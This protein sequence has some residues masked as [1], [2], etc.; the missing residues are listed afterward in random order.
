DG[1]GSG[2]GSAP[3]SRRVP[4]VPGRVDGDAGVDGPE[5]A[6]REVRGRAAHVCARG[7]DAGQQVAPERHVPQSRSELRHGDQRAVPEGGG[8]REGSVV[9]WCGGGA[10][11]GGPGGVW[12]DGRDVAAG[13]VTVARRTGGKAPVRLDDLAAKVPEALGEM[14]GAWR[15]A[16]WERREQLSIR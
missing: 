16:A 9:G 2:S 14:Q 6:E 12:L 13:R 1:G 4:A 11:R 5:D 8:G 10:A 15:Q 7:A 3:D